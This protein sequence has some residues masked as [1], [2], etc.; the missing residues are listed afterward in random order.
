M[1][2]ADARGVYIGAVLVIYTYI[3]IYAFPAGMYFIMLVDM[4]YTRFG[5][6]ESLL[7]TFYYVADFFVASD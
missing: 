4:Q 5:E 2:L 1:I 7:T 3:C 6:L